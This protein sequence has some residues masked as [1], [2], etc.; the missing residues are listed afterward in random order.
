MSLLMS[1]FPILFDDYYWFLGDY[2]FAL[3]RTRRYPEGGV[4]SS[5]HIPGER[6]A[7]WVPWLAQRPWRPL[8]RPKGP[9]D[10]CLPYPYASPNRA[11]GVSGI[12]TI[13][14]RVVRIG[15]LPDLAFTSFEWSLRSNFVSGYE[16]SL[17]RS[18]AHP[19]TVEV[20]PV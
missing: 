15:G 16:Y 14:L 3:L 20:N 10:P 13:R 17:V 8:V 7:C 1:S 19:A 12:F 5:R 2:M 6:P 4:G 18:P 9:R 11:K